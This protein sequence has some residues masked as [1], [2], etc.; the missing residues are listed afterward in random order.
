MGAAEC[1]LCSSEK[2]RVLHGRAPCPEGGLDPVRELA[3]VPF[4]RVL[5]GSIGPSKVAAWVP[6]TRYVIADMARTWQERA[7]IL[8]QSDPSP[9]PRL[10]LFRRRRSA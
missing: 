2:V 10:R 3:L 5:P 9:F 1:S 6:M 7:V 8:R 4:P